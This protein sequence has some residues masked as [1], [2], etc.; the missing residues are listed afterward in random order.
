MIKKY[1]IV[2]VLLL[3]LM[4]TMPFTA[5][6]MEGITVRIP[7]SVE[8]APGTIVIKAIDD[9]PIPVMT[10]FTNVTEGEFE[11]D[12]TEP[13]D[14]YYSIRQLVG[15]AQ[16]ITYDETVY[17]ALVSV[18]ADENGELY[19]VLTVSAAGHSHKPERI[20]FTNTVEAPDPGIDPTPDRP[21]VTLPADPSAPPDEIIDGPVID[22]E[23]LDPGGSP[24]YGDEGVLTDDDPDVAQ[25]SAPDELP[26][27]SSDPS[28][29]TALVM[30]DEETPSPIPELPQTGQIWW[31]VPIMLGI[32]I[33]LIG[34]GIMLL[35][36]EPKEQE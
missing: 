19:A 30:E 8:K 6:A 16:S 7:F 29:G 14:Y 17:T 22:D 28:E 4:V 13:G 23:S 20:V 25:V 27:A 33:L 9:A 31:P 15:T 5:F 18:F 2:L 35:R 3:L 36:K 34:T 1:C 26:D 24:I 21:Q 12:F 11:I 10:E 32:G